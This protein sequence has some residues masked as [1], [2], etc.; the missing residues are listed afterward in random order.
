MALIDDIMNDALKEG[1]FDNLPG[2]GKQLRIDDDPNTP[3]AMKMAYKI[4]KDNDLAPAWIEE[5]KGLERTEERLM[6]QIKVGKITT[7][8]RAEVERYNKQVLAFNLKL[9]PGILHRRMIHLK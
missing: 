8:L 5:G 3:E 7:A 4:M 1:K 9:P 2:A 6:T